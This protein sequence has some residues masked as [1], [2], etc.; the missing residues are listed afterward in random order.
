MRNNFLA[1][2]VGFLLGALIVFSYYSFFPQAQK[3]VCLNGSGS[4]EA[5]FSPNSE[6]EIINFLRSARTS[7]DVEMY[8]FTHPKLADELI[9]ARARGVVV[10]IILE[11]RVDSPN[12]NLQMMERLRDAGI[13][14]RWASLE[15]SRTHSKLAIV[16]GKKV[17]VGS[18]NWGRSALNTNREAAVIIEDEDV[19]REFANIFEDDWKKASSAGNG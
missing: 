12:P 8:I 19:A 18:I 16:D 1:L 17:L 5:V 10:R 6:D 2:F 15:F 4:V 7:I 3:Q 9:A 14:A 11:P 13:E